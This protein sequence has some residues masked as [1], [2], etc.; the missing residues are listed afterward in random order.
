VTL[1]SY[2]SADALPAE[3]AA[4]QSPL[5]GNAESITIPEKSGYD[6]CI[7]LLVFLLSLFYLHFFYDYTLISSDEGIILQG[8]QRILQGEVLYR[9]FF[10]FFTPGSYYWMALF[11]KVFGSSIL[12]G[13]AVLMVEG[14]LF[15]VLI[16]LLARRGCSRWSALL[17]AYFVTLSCLPSAFMVVHNWDSTLW[18]CLALYC[19]VRFLERSRPGWALATGSFASLTCL[20]EQSK[21]AGLVLGL[22]AGFLILGWKERGRVRWDW[23]RM[24]A[25][26]AGFLGPFLFTLIYFGLK[27]SLPQLLADWFWPLHHYTP[28]NSVPLGFLGLGPAERDAIYAGPPLSLLL[29]LLI[30]GPCYMV[31][32]LPVLAAFSLIH[33]SAKAWRENPAPG[34]GAYY[35]LSSATLVGLLISTLATR[36]PDFAHFLY[37]SPLFFLVLAWILDG[38][39]I[40]SSLLRAAR[41]MLVFLLILSFT[42]YGMAHLW[43]PLNARQRLETRRGTLKMNGS[44]NVLDYVQAHVSAGESMLVYPYLPLYYYL[45][46]TRSP[47]R[48][49]CLLPG[50]HSPQQAEELRSELDADRTRVVLFAPLYREEVIRQFPAV[51]LAGLAARDPVEDYISTHYRACAS[52]MSRDVWPFVFMIRKDLPCPG[53]A[54]SGK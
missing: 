20:F 22:S 26:L 13:R 28:F 32:V 5:D 38:R 45:T 14:G 46:A 2:L 37:L 23:Q 51:T 27:H 39:D 4:P 18:A 43:Q 33:W 11:L 34:K 49:E 42:A 30:T 52:L 41:P 15:S 7:S 12:V 47:G 9:D 10:S 31:S 19:A 44:E 50:L 17:A 1:L 16:Y 36:R 35:V 53:S 25:L 8:A 3:V 6:L 54:S 21:G 40:P 48:Y 24:A 29:A